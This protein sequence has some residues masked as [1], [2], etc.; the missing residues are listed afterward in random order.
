MAQKVLVTTDF[1]ASKLDRLALR[2]CERIM[3]VNRS[4]K[5]LLRKSFHPLFQFRWRVG[6]TV[7]T[8]AAGTRPC[9]LTLPHVWPLEPRQEAKHEERKRDGEV[10]HDLLVVTVNPLRSHSSRKKS[11]QSERHMVT[12]KA[13]TLIVTYRRRVRSTLDRWNASILSS[14]P[15]MNARILGVRF[16]PAPE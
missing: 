12:A 4:Q 15:E 5:P 8:I 16:T 13:F 2:S 7:F 11:R 6:A 1:V 14:S 3:H 9:L 10:G